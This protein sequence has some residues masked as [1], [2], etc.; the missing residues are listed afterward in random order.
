MSLETSELAT[1]N[2]TFR[3]FQFSFKL[4]QDFKK[5][6]LKGYT[7]PSTFNYAFFFKSKHNSTSILS[8]KQILHCA[9]AHS[10]EILMNVMDILFKPK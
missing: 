3:K 8:F 6:S 2:N 1:K 9:Q 5:F 7:K 4:E 10:L